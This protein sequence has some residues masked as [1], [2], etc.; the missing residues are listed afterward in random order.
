M[1][2]G[3]KMRV[4]GEYTVKSAQFCNQGWSTLPKASHKRCILK[5]GLKEE[6]ILHWAHLGLSKLILNIN[7]LN[8]YF[9]LSTLWHGTEP[10]PMVP[11]M[12]SSSFLLTKGTLVN[13]SLCMLNEKSK[14]KSKS[15]YSDIPEPNV[16]SL[17]QPLARS[18]IPEPSCY[19]TLWT[20]V[21]DIAEQN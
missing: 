15:V 11:S 21:Q 4:R 17:L 5:L 18:C 10:D 13:F 19:S 9:E 12:Y 3:E 2:N 6:K 7:F 16:L 8:I 1:G 14:M 20:L